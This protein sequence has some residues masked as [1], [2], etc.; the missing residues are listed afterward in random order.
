MVIIWMIQ[1]IDLNQESGRYPD[2]QEDS[3]YPHFRR[4][5][6]FNVPVDKYWKFCT[7]YR[8]TLAPDKISIPNLFG[9]LEARVRYYM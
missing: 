1:I 9:L 5:F 3:K 8:N 6:E 2:I 4:N 7:L